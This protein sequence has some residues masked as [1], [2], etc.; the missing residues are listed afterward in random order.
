MWNRGT[1][2]WVPERCSEMISAIEKRVRD[3]ISRY[4]GKI[5]YFSVVNEATRPFRPIFE[6][7]KMT[8]CYR[9][10]GRDEFVF[11][12]LRA[13][14]RANPTGKMVINETAVDKRN[15]GFADLLKALKDSHGKLL[16]DVIGIQSHMHNGLWSLDQVW[17]L[18]ELYAGF[19][20]PIHFT[21]LTVLSGT[22]I[23]GKRNSFGMYTTAQGERQQAEYAVKLYTLL[24]SHP[25]VESIQWWNLTDLGAFRN[26]PGGLLRKDMSP[27]PAYFALM[28]L[29][30][31][32]WRTKVKTKT[33][34]KG[35][36]RFKGFYGDYRVTITAESGEPISFKIKLS[37]KGER[38]FNLIL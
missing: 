13:A 33:S 2:D 29:I 4:S 8:R 15:K 6:K 19:G 22:P 17:E 9:E 25:A 7:D 5:D 16:F 10:V 21:E 32:K 30:W 37:K 31:K 12:A 14:R 18:C 28:D 35:E 3:F 34:D 26:A 24:F 1:P 36:C 27:K 20:V 23:G 11:L 38:K